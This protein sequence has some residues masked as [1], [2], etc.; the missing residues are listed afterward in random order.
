MGQGIQRN[1]GIYTQWKKENNKKQVRKAQKQI[2]MSNLAPTTTLNFLYRL[3]IRS[4]YADAESYLMSLE[5]SDR[6]IQYYESLKTVLNAALANLELIIARYIIKKVFGNWVEEIYAQN[7]GMLLKTEIPMLIAHRGIHFYYKYKTKN[8]A[9]SY[10]PEKHWNKQRIW[11]LIYG[12]T[13]EKLY[14]YLPEECNW[15]T[16]YIQKKPIK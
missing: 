13:P 7:T 5:N 9:F 1:G 16:S 11:R 12:I 14:N 10:K 8:E 2:L 4:N 15:N 3:R 6:A